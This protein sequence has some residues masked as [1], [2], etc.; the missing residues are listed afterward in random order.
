MK[1]LGATEFIETFLNFGYT[2]FRSDDASLIYDKNISL[3]G[4]SGKAAYVIGAISFFEASRRD[5]TYQ[6]DAS[7]GM[8]EAFNIKVEYVQDKLVAGEEI[9]QE[10]LDALDKINEKSFGLYYRRY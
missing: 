3:N 4:V 10:D 5:E 2:E 6:I 1:T 7:E 9:T 8:K